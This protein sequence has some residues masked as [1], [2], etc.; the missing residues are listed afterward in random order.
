MIPAYAAKQDL[1]MLL[2]TDHYG[3]LNCRD[4]ELYALNRN[5]HPFD[6]KNPPSREYWQCFDSKNIVISYHAWVNDDITGE[7]NCDMHIIVTLNNQKTHEYGLR[8]ALPV[9]YCIEKNALWNNM[10]KNQPYTCLGGSYVGESKKLIQGN[11]SK[12]KKWVY[13]KIKTKKDYD[14]YFEDPEER[15]EFSMSKLKRSFNL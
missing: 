7:Q 6:S 4:L 3:I 14:S 5:V 10:I 15:K 8:R 1:L 12:V 9:E 13:D 11:K 2:L